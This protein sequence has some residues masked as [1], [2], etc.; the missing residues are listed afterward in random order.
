M[1]CL[2]AALCG[3]TALAN[4]HAS[5]DKPW[6]IF[7]FAGI[8]TAN[9]IFIEQI[10]TPWQPE[11]VR[12]H[13]AGGAVS[14][15]LV[16]FHKHWIVDGEIGAGYRSGEVKSPEGWVALYLRYD[17]FPWSH[18]LYTT[19]AMNVGLSFVE[20]ISEVERVSC[21]GRGNPYCAKVLHY[22]SPEITFAAPQY[23][24][25]ELVVRWHHR[26]G[27]WGLFNGVW[28]GS[29]ITTVCLRQRF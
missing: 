28:G 23:R 6:S 29:N 16:R 27:A 11:Y 13:F 21:E 9:T 3:S 14:R 25:T 15:R 7:A 10:F 19:A 4:D 5:T 26:S 20:K 12:P 8:A 1:H 22:L 17:G 2:V 18:L 24:D